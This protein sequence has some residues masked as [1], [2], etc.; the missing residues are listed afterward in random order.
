MAPASGAHTCRRLRRKGEEIADYLVDA[1][2][3]LV[4]KCEDLYE[5]SEEAVEDAN[6][7]LSGKYRALHEYSR[8]LLD[9]AEM[10]LRRTKSAAIGR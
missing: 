1:G 7:E 5:R 6:H 4:D 9:E 8:Q 3:E 10:I 2:K